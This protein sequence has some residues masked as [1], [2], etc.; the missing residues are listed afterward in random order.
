[1][2]NRFRG[3]VRHAIHLEEGVPVAVTLVLGDGSEALAHLERGDVTQ[4]EG[5]PLSRKKKEWLWEIGAYLAQQFLLEESQ[6][7]QSEITDG[8]QE[9]AFQPRPRPEIVWWG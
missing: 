4:N 5:P 9:I 2:K 6:Q 8:R 7:R 1:M 3:V